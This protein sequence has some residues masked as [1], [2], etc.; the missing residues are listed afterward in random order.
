MGSF[1]TI[2][3]ILFIFWPFWVIFGLFGVILGHFWPFF[4]ANSFW[5]HIHLCYSNRFLQLWLNAKFENCKVKDNPNVQWLLQLLRHLQS[6]TSIAKKVIFLNFD[7]FKN[8]NKRLNFA[9]L[10]SVFLPTKM[11][12]FCPSF[13]KNEP[14]WRIRKF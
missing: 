6:K 11:P 1:F 8:R 14:V 12:V 7:I 13:Y 10:T 4:G 5:Q 3:A 2:L 9:H